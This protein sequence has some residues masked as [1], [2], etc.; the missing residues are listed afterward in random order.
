MKNAGAQFLRELASREYV[1]AVV[2]TCK[3]GNPVVET[4]ARELLQ[5]WA[6]L[7]GRSDAA[8]QYMMEAYEQT[9]RE[10]L[11]FPPP[12]AHQ[13]YPLNPEKLLSTETPPEWSD[14][15]NCVRCNVPFTMLLRKHH[16]RKCGKTFCQQ[17]S[18]K[19]MPLPE[20][21]LYDEVRVCESCYSRKLADRTASEHRRR[22]S[23]SQASPTAYPSPSTE[24]DLERAI[25]LSLQET[26][27][28]AIVDAKS[29]SYDEEAAL[30][31]A[32]AAS[33]DESEV[34]HPPAALAMPFD[35]PGTP[36][37]SP[38]GEDFEETPLITPIERE[39][40]HLFS[41][42][43]SRLR[44]EDADDDELRDL[45]LKMIELRDRLRASSSDHS[46]TL[47]ILD[48]LEEALCRHELL[49]AKHALRT[50]DYSS[51][52]TRPR[53]RTGSIIGVEDEPSPKSTAAPEASLPPFALPPSAEMVP[54]LKPRPLRQE[55]SNLLIPNLHEDD[56]E[57]ARAVDVQNMSGEN[58]LAELLE[59][60]PL[61]QL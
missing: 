4:R 16:C 52:P 21:A 33:L 32:I 40:V 24:D 7:L 22:Q 34:R 17:C 28:A 60:A 36:S 54:V 51:I 48:I 55:A 57:R 56:D 37:R 8:L 18:G 59:D 53:S 44:G 27:P 1:D 58:P 49:S 29:A 5:S 43:V 12:P 14:S 20:L 50:A 9:K 23:S 3:Q 31:A 30:A 47:H 35:V 45:A 38:Q 26:G 11:V 2:E 10:G 46:D 25:R 15:S 13:E 61:I 19:T 41:E 39:N 6:L 42:L